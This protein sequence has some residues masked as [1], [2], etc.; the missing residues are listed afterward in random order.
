VGS[1]STLFTKKK[2]FHYILTKYL[3]LSFVW[4]ISVWQRLTNKIIS[5]VLG[6]RV[7]LKQTN[8]PMKSVKFGFVYCQ[9][10][11]SCRWTSHIKVFFLTDI[12]FRDFK[13]AS[14]RKSTSGMLVSIYLPS[15]IV[16]ISA[17]SFFRCCLI[18]KSCFPVW[19][20][21]FSNFWMKLR[22]SKLHQLGKIPLGRKDS[23]MG[24][25]MIR[26]EIFTNDFF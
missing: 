7:D 8:K 5:F 9:R 22:Q 24:F 23:Y 4:K 20:R 2:H 18:S 25:C 17:I 21:K 11:W 3:K 14:V 10:R 26:D 15:E 12:Y 1:G 16:F 13:I 19:F 6:K